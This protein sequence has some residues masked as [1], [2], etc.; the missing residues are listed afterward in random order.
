MKNMKLKMGLIFVIGALS[1]AV[2]LFGSVL[3]A[4]YLDA[5][6]Y[7]DDGP[8]LDLGLLI[9]LFSFLFGVAGALLTVWA[10]RRLSAA[11][12]LHLLAS[13][14]FVLLTAAFIDGPIALVLVLFE[15][16]L[17]AFLFGS[18]VVFFIARRKRIF[19]TAIAA[20]SQP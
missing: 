2:W 1:G 18:A 16:K 3:P 9:L 6:L 8:V 11:P 7:T 20:A 12:Y 19:E 15:K 13:A 4:L 5:A 10:G 17:W 14:V